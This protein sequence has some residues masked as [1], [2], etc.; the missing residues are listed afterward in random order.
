MWWVVKLKL[1][2]PHPTMPS[3]QRFPNVEC[4]LC[5]VKGVAFMYVHPSELARAYQV[6]LASLFS[7]FSV[8]CFGLVLA[9]AKLQMT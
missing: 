5:N 3:G 6:I 1:T 7:A 4:P 8:A 2:A 9:D